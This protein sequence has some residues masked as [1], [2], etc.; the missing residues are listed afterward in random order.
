[1]FGC[2]PPLEELPAAQY[3]LLIAPPTRMALIAQMAELE[4]LLQSMA[5]SLKLIM[6]GACLGGGR[7]DPATPPHSPCAGR[8]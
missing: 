7:V 8:L 3:S 1:M 2:F 6:S 5:S 4:Q